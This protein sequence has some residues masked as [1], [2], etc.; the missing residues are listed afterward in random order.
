[1]NDGKAIK[2]AP[3]VEFVHHPSFSGGPT[4]ITFFLV[5]SY[6]L[7]DINFSGYVM[8]SKIVG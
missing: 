2:T 5:G 7:Y 6:L 1:M 4:A 3:Y 8:S